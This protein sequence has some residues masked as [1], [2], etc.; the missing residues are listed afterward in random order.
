[1]HNLGFLQSRREPL[2]PLAAMCYGNLLKQEYGG[3]FWQDGPV[4]GHLPGWEEMQEEGK[5]DFHRVAR[6]NK[7]YFGA[8][9]EGVFF[10]ATSVNSSLLYKELL[11]LWNNF[12]ANGEK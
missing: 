10:D 3:E 5:E 11:K 12:R 7:L 4:Q 2:S 1:M 6:V 8:C 9:R